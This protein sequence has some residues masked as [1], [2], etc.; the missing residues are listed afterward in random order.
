M[1]AV[2]AAAWLGVATGIVC[3]S[4]VGGGAHAAASDTRTYADVPRVTVA[5]DAFF[6]G[7]FESARV[8]PLRVAFF[9]DSQ[10]TA[11]AGFG[12][13][14]LAF[15]N[16]R[17]TRVFGPAHETILFTNATAVTRPQWLA[18]VAASTALGT[19]QTPAA[20]IPPNIVVHALRAA[21]GDR[22]RALRVVFLPDA[23]RASDPALV[24]GPWFATGA[25][26][27]AEVVVRR[28]ALREALRWWNAPTDGDT[29]DGMAPAVAAG[30]LV[31]PPEAKQGSYAALTTP[32]LDL[33]G[34]R[35]LQ[36]QLL[37]VSDRDPQE[38][39][40]VRF[41]AEH[42]G[43]KGG[44]GE[45]GGV[46]GGGVVLQS[47]ARG[48]MRLGDLVEDHGASAAILAAVGPRLAVLHYGANDAAVVE[49][50]RDAWRAKLLEAVA[51]IRASLADPAFPVIIAAELPL[52][53]STL[54]AERIDWMPVVAHDLALEDPRILALNL[55]RITE[56]EYGWGRT[57]MFHLFDTAH[58]QP[59]AQRLEAE[60]FVGELCAALGI[61]DPACAEPS[62]ADCVRR[63]GA[64]C[65]SGGCREII[66]V[67]AELFGLAWGGVGST[68]D[69][70]DG[71]GSPDLCPPG[72]IADINRDGFVDGQ[73][74]AFVLADWGAA[75]G[76]ADLDRDGVVGAADLAIVLGAWGK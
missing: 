52:G 14:Y 64:R 6:R 50:T 46:E 49:V 74:L 69:D 1:A 13:H 67:E 30:T 75:G 68:C 34:R 62:W 22:T 66:D 18:T 4:A 33:A 17:F 42:G 57:S 70:G 43:A 73:D 72:G 59:Y 24:G 47:L 63:W 12:E 37:G 11:P 20:E 19:A 25:P 5:D 44:G 15:L 21:K 31:F 28:G 76:I 61:D 2:R 16:A 45:G 60:A 48:G 3:A 65:A 23:A 38:V 51:W 27:R 39:V 58:F 9:G 53:G 35:H 56:E 41:R 71:D 29:P 36:L 40:G 8:Q 32:P 54:A 26:I 55:R 7:L 10:E